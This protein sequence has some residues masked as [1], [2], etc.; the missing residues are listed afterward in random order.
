MDLSNVL[1]SDKAPYPPVEVCERNPQ[2]AA[3]MLSNIGSCNSEMSAV[4]LYLY[5]SLI[6]KELFQDIAHCFH[7]ISIV[8]M[9]H[10]NLFG[11][12]ALKLG[13]DP[14]LWNQDKGTMRYWCPGCNRYPCQIGPLLTNSLAGELEAIRKYEEQAQWI[15]D[16][17]IK[18][19][20]NRIIADEQCHVRIFKQLIAEIN[21]EPCTQ[22]VGAQ[23]VQTQDICPIAPEPKNSC[24][25]DSA[26]V[27][28]A[29]VDPM[30]ENIPFSNAYIKSSSASSYT[31]RAGD[32]KS[33]DYRSDDYRS[34]N[35]RAGDY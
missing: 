24:P 18:A 33:G 3:A 17:K 34:G 23:T 31:K 16:C 20:L 11:E 28:A 5:N 19:I 14:R 22:G 32:Y 30:P 2:Y 21:C 8:E 13:A 12:L 35:Y 6:T 7:K 27:S 9:H 1:F 25:A 26:V 29:S 10:L 4:S 15:K